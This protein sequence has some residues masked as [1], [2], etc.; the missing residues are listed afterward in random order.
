MHIVY[1]WSHFQAPSTICFVYVSQQQQQQQHYTNTEYQYVEREREKE[2]KHTQNFDWVSLPQSNCVWS[3]HRWFS[4]SLARFAHMYRMYIF[5][6][7]TRWMNWHIQAKRPW[8]L[9]TVLKP[10]RVLATT[11]LLLLLLLLL[12]YIII[13]SLFLFYW[14]P[15]NYIIFIP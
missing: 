5:K 13:H 12:V 3:V 11:V 8:T 14:I 15:F 1:N 9:S 10:I 2:G 7:W 4:D 6:Q